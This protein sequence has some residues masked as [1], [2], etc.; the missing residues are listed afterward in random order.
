MDGFDDNSNIVVLAATN[1]GQ[2]LD[3]ALLR[4]GRFD[5]HITLTLPDLEARK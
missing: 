2:V 5:R 4:P 1:R 3:K